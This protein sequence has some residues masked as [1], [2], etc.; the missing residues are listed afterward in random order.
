[1]KILEVIIM[2]NG[3]IK[4]GLLFLTVCLVGCST[5]TQKENTAT[6]AVGGGVLGGLAG[7]LIGAG[8]GQA[9]AIGA[10]IIAGA[11]IGG[12]I[13]HEADSSD[14]AKA[15]AA[16]NDNPPNKCTTWKNKKTHKQYSV[17]PT[18]NNMTMNGNPNCRTYTTVIQLDGKTEKTKGTACRQEN[19]NWNIIKA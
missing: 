4:L 16:M 8:T 7:S 1:M 6:G 19:G 15:N 10:G 14:T 9:V 17:K 3:L 12:Y 11:L 5:N 2:K 18:S 13:G